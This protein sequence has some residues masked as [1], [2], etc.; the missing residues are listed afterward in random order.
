MTSICFVAMAIYV[1]GAIAF[2]LPAA[3]KVAGLY[4]STACSLIGQCR[5]WIVLSA[6]PVFGFLAVT[7]PLWGPWALAKAVDGDER[8]VPDALDPD[9]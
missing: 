1:F 9:V 4:A 6:I 2:G 3:V 8:F 7:Y 5:W